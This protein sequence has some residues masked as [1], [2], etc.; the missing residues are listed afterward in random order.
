MIRLYDLTTF[1]PYTSAKRSQD[2][3]AAVTTVLLLFF[4]LSLPRR[5]SSASQQLIWELLTLTVRWRS[6]HRVTCLRL[7]LKMAAFV[8]GRLLLLLACATSSKLISVVRWYS[9]TICLNCTCLDNGS[10]QSKLYLSWQSI[11]PPVFALYLL[12]GCCE[13]LPPRVG[14][15]IHQLSLR[16][17]KVC[18]VQFSKN[19]KLLLSSGR[20]SIVRLWDVGTGIYRPVLTYLLPTCC[21][22]LPSFLVIFSKSVK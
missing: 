18:S 20:D 4:P 1:Q 12:W 16:I 17:C 22:A 10:S 14:L 19:N 5:L 13:L 21:S 8:F 9:I 6:H 15:S 3:L 2:H 7:D 11:S